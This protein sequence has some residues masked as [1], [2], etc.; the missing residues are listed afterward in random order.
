SGCRKSC[1]SAGGRGS[2][3]YAELKATCGSFSVQNASTETRKEAPT[4]AQAIRLVFARPRALP[5]TPFTTAPASGSAMISQRPCAM[6]AGST[7][8]VMKN[9]CRQS[10]ALAWLRHSVKAMGGRPSVLHRPDFLDVERAPAAKYRDHDRQ[11]DRRLRGCHRDHEEGGDV[12]HVVRALA[13]E[14]EKGQIGRT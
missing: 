2:R 3:R 4:A 10:A 13:S 7:G 8:A 5:K 11:P 1:A 14:S 12:S 6:L 9:R